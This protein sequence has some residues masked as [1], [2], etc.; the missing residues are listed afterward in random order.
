MCGAVRSAVLNVEWPRTY[1]AR[2]WVFSIKTMKTHLSE[3]P[4][5][6]GYGEWERVW[7]QW[8]GGECSE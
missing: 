5:R 6:D 2:T 8:C 4:E 1:G 7:W 3:D